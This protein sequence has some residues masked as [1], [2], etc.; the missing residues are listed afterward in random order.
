MQTPYTSHLQCEGLSWYILLPLH[1][2]A[3][4]A[5][6]DDLRRCCPQG[7]YI[8]SK[9]VRMSC[10]G[11]GDLENER[12]WH[13]RTWINCYQ[14][15]SLQHQYFCMFLHSSFFYIYILMLSK[16]LGWSTIY[17]ERSDGHFNKDHETWKSS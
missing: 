16:M 14:N 12:D 9:V 13:R 6:G 11:C 4:S 3:F 7:D 2:E 5:K 17:Q 15:I 1:P 10:P 8:H